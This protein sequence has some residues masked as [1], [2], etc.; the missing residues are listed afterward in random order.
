VAASFF[1]MQHYGVSHSIC[2]IWIESF[3]RRCRFLHARYFP[4]LRRKIDR[5]ARFYVLIL[6][7]LN[8]KTTGRDRVF[9][10]PT[11][12][13]LSYRQTYLDNRASC[14]PV[15]LPSRP[16]SYNLKNRRADNQAGS[17]HNPRQQSSPLE[18]QTPGIVTSFTIEKDDIRARGCF[19][20][21]PKCQSLHDISG[22]R[23]TGGIYFGLFLDGR[24]VTRVI[25]RRPVTSF[26]AEGL[27][28]FSAA[29]G[30]KAAWDGSL[31]AAALWRDVK[32][33]DLGVGKQA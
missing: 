9:E 13:H 19:G 28:N 30:V 8:T 16:S 25:R 12:I 15:L 33:D 31:A 17:V 5:P 10:I 24:R 27:P 20:N 23:R 4:Q 32:A 6:S 3:A 21:C 29:P 2:S 7:L 1:N 18:S 11:M 14:Q 22:F 26:T